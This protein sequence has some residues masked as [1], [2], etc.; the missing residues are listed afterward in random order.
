MAAWPVRSHAAIN[1][2]PVMTAALGITFSVSGTA[3]LLIRP[4]SVLAQA[5]TFLVNAEDSKT[6][7]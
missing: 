2:I 5:D 1:T 6:T 3:V 7:G 4:A